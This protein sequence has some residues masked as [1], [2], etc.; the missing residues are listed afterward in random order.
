M[1][2]AKV[3]IDKAFTERQA[4]IEVPSNSVTIHQ[5][6]DKKEYSEIIPFNILPQ[7]LSSVNICS[8]VTEFDE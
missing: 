8:A 3:I 5:L 7:Q 1:S 4:K 2:D 6:R